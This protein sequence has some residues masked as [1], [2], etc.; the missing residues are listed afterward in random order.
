MSLMGSL[1]SAISALAAQSQALSNISSNLANSSTTAYKASSTSFS[2]LI[3]GSSTST[4][5]GVT[6]S[7]RASFSDQGLLTATGT[8]TN[9]A[10]DG[11]GFFVVSSSVTGG[12]TYYTRNG[13]FEVDQN[14]YLVNNG[15]YLMGW[16]TDADGNIIGGTSEASL[17]PIDIDAIQSSVGA[18]TAVGIQANLPADAVE[19]DTFSTTVEIYDSLGSTHNMSVTWTKTGENTWE[20]A[21]DDPTLNGTTSGT[22]STDAIEITFNS[23]GTLASTNPSPA[24]LSVT[25][26]T[27]GA[28]DTEVTLDLGTSGLANGLTQY[29]SGSSDPYLKLDKITNDGL[30]YGSLTGV[31]ITSDGSVIASYDNGDERT[32]YKIPV[33]TFTNS[34]GLTLNSDGMYSRSPT[35]GNST[36]Q[37]AGTSGAGSINGGYLEASTT[38]TSTEFSRM[39][40]AQQAYSAASQIIS[41]SNS[42]FDSLLQAVR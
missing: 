40:T 36:L 11:S 20:M 18:T 24:T 12:Q 23:D 30:P 7:T 35:S 8:S 22:V 38:D 28:A 19:G 1:N 4:S 14:G 15:Y 13:E 9:L 26:W 34:N 37:I 27:T 2:N 10:I 42:M 5:G 29:A 33:A 39:L 32:I 3:A 6:A 31:S 25:G 17:V 41:T 16:Q 21:F